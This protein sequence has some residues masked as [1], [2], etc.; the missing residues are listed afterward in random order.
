MWSSAS[1]VK[2]A[3]SM[4][5][6][7][8]I[9]QIKLYLAS[10]FQL[11]LK[12]AKQQHLVAIVL[13]AFGVRNK[14]HLFISFLD[15][16]FYSGPSEVQQKCK[17]KHICKTRASN[18]QTTQSSLSPPPP[19]FLSGI[20][21]EVLMAWSGARSALCCYALQVQASKALDRESLLSLTVKSW[22]NICR[23]HKQIK[24]KQTRNITFS[25][26]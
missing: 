5:H 15:K 22:W 20:P 7:Y 1:Y 12:G 2:Y 9:R 19:L 13:T 8:A 14:K 11:S 16:L 6:T 24:S 21:T 23:H 10:A 18:Y 3:Y 4:N 26:C 17:R 25:K